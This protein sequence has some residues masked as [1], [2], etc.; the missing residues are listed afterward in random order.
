MRKPIVL[1]DA[2]TSPPALVRAGLESLPVII[3]ARGERAEPPLDRIL[4]R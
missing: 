2:L 3:R 1:T 4:H